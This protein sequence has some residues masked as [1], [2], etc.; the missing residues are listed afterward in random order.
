MFAPAAAARPHKQAPLARVP[1]RLVAALCTACFFLG[2]CVVNRYW[3]VPELPDCRTKVNSDNPGAVMNQVSQT[4]EVI[5]ALDRTISEIEMRLAAA[6]TMQARSQGLSPSDSGSDQGSTRARL[7]FVM[8]IVTTFANRKRRDSIRQTWLPQG[9]HLQ[10][11]EKEKGV[12][13]RFVIGRSANPSPDS[14][15]ERAIAAEDK[16]YN[17]ILR[18]DHVERNGSLPLKIQ[19]FL[20]T[21]LSIWD[22]DFYVKVDDD[23]HVNIGI[24]RS[25]LARHRSKP[26]VY[27]GCM[28]SGPVVDKNESKYYEPDHWKFGTE[29]NNYFR[30]AT[31][32]LYAVTRDLATYISANRHIL[33]KYSNE[34]VSFGSWLI[35]LDV[36]H[37]DERS[38]CCGTPP[39]CEWKAQAGN[40]CAASFDW[41]CTGICN[42]V[43]RMEE[44][45]RRCWEG[46][47]ADLQAQF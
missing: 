27:I 33:H 20:S 30:H 4:R 7:F 25:I 10:R 1:T 44:V 43:E 37:V 39:D 29:G 6:R 38:L 34:D 19:M 22:A 15:V 3:A 18:L 23:V 36:E 41:N 12:V 31:R 8:G 21:A 45:H 42:P 35:G 2:V 16:E 13:I 17:D 5:I 9:E 46:H 24:T 14:E 26:R 40:P 11:L 47:V 32:Q 28:K